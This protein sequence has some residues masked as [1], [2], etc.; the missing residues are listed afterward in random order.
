MVFQRTVQ[1]DI[2]EDHPLSSMTVRF[3]PWLFRL[4]IAPTKIHGQIIYF[5]ER[6]SSSQKRPLSILKTV[7]FDSFNSTRVFS[8]KKFYKNS[9]KS[10]TQVR[11]LEFF[12]RTFSKFSTGWVRRKST[13]DEWFQQDLCNQNVDKMCKNIHIILIRIDEK[14]R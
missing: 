2:L 11:N 7:Y 5:R 9:P 6:F 10:L 14:Y 3:Y 8:R 4:K 12:S 1:I 13:S